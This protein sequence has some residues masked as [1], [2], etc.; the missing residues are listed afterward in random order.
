MAGAG[1]PLSMCSLARPVGVVT[2]VSR[3]FGHEL[4]EQL[5]AHA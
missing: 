1:D 2:R 4:A 3:D 5:A